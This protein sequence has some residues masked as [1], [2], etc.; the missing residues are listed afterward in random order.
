VPDSSL[1]RPE[2]IDPETA[3]F[4]AQLQLLLATVPPIHTQEPQKIRDAR[5]AGK[6]IF[7]PIVRSPMAVDRTIPGP[8]EPVPVRVFVPESV[9]GV[10]LHLHGGGH[11][12]GR[13]HHS[14]ERN[15]QI[16]RL[17]SLAVVSVDYRLAPEHP[18]PEGPDDCEAAAIWLARNAKA[19]FGSDRIA[20]GGE[21]AG[22]NL[23]AITLVRMRDRQGF[24]GF[25]AANLVFGVFDLSGTPSV[26]NWGDLELVLSAKTMRWFG[27]H[28]V[29]ANRRREPDVSPLYADL[30]D[31]PP[32]LFTVGTLDPLLDDSLFMYAR[33]LAAGNG[34]ELQVYA[35]GVHGFTAFS[36]PLA[37]EANAR[38]D[39]FL[40]ENTP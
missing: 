17:Q 33:W 6:G 11:V 34:A 20:I 4:N 35:G 40:A 29:P 28:Y 31:L 37:R 14:D 13:A 36:Y 5:E 24:T 32:A 19:E 1:F 9:R 30:H 39:G 7:G 25:A 18:Y 38:I 3:A 22:A 23:A 8:A 2:A 26:Q 10:Y 21:S 15:E 16:A 12:L 27:D